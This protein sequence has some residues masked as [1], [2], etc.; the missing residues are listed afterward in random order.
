MSELLRRAATAE[1]LWLGPVGAK[2]LLSGSDT[3]GAFAVVEAPIKPRSL[4][5]P[6][7]VHHRED[8]WWYV[9]EGELAA[10]VGEH[11]ITAGPGDL[12]F[13]PKR[14][15]HTYWN[16]G[17]AP[18]RYLEIFMPAGLEEYLTRLGTLIADGASAGIESALALSGEYQL[19]MDWDSVSRLTEKHG[20]TLV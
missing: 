6:L 4:A 16:P 1:T 15:P 20:V 18:A 12:V 5:G 13:A 2:I 8:G 3:Q 10:Q 17:S 11:E 9:L 14:V 7:H 19:D